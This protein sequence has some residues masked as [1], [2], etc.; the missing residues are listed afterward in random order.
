MRGFTIYISFIDLKHLHSFHLPLLF[1]NCEGTSRVLRFLSQPILL[2][3]GFNTI[4]P[5]RLLSTFLYQLLPEAH[6][7]PV[8]VF[9]FLLY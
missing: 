2:L 9:P 4:A 5:Q 7:I 6:K 3:P 1:C 8:A